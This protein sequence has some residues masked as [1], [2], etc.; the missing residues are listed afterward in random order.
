M[1]FNLTIIINFIL[2]YFI[3]NNI[4]DLVATIARDIY[5]Q[6]L[7]LFF[8]GQIKINIM[9]MMSICRWG[10]NDIEIIYY[11]IYIDV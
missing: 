10:K 7:W 2:F 6:L 1:Y 4:I 5:I 9:N 11:S 8:E 3:Y